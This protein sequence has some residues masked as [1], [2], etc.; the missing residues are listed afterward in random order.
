VYLELLKRT[1]A[2]LIYEDD[3]YPDGKFDFNLRV[4]G[5]DWPSKA[6]TMLGMK[7][8]NNIQECIE[9]VIKDKVPGDFIEC[10]AWRG[11]GAI[12]MQGVR[13]YYNEDRD[14]WVADSFNGFPPSVI[15]KKVYK[16]LDNHRD[17]HCVSIDDVRS[18]FSKY[19]LLNDHVKFVPG[20]LGETLPCISI[21]KLALLHCDVDLYPSV[22]CVLNYLYPKLSPGGYCIIDDYNLIGC[23]QAVNHYRARRGIT[24]PM[25]PVDWAGVY[26]RKS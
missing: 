13:E 23:R 4:E 1:L 26:W 8:L 14:V 20:W 17:Y 11:G 15:E 10:G 18:N 2:G 6:H 9:S 12:L 3:R 22:K 25:L 24:E 21:S 7:R 19:N 16:N 5:R